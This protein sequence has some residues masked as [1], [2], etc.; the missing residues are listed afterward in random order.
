MFEFAWPWLLA[1]LPLPL[2]IYWLV[3]AGEDRSAALKAPLL[4][5]WQHF[6][7]GG[8]HRQRQRLW[9]KSLLWALLVTAAAR[10]QWVGEPLELPASGRDLLI[11]VDISGSMEA[12]DM[13]LNQQPVNRLQAVKVLLRDFIER[14]QGDRLGLILFGENAYLQTPLTFD[15]KTVGTMLE[16]TEIGLAGTSRTAIGDGIGLA[17]K[18]LRERNAQNRVLILL[19]DGQNNAGALD[20]VQ[21]A[22]LAAHAGVTVYTI[23]VG[24]D[25]MVVNDT[26][27]GRR[28]INPSKELDEETLKN[29]AGLTGGRYFRA[30]NTAELEQI[31][32]ILDRLE[33]VP[34][35]P[36]TF[37]PVKAL[38]FMPLGLALL[39]S[40][41]AFLWQVRPRWQGAA[42]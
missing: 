41:L 11:S 34:D 7:S 35:T 4:L 8:Q 5:H 42:A 19:T 13:V 1:L 12:E 40:A 6:E 15:R 26:F 18:R 10:P 30:R 32:Q 36:E 17:V 2:L 20:P 16:D 21:A 37:R 31:Y 27:F 33:P 3:P 29:V 28:V 14:R 23:G 22:E 25:A 38:F 9:L 24:A 39:I